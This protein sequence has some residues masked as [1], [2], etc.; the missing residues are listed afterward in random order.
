[1]FYRRLNPEIGQVAV[2]HKGMPHA[3]ELRFLTLALSVQSGVGIGRRGVRVI[4][5]RLPVKV[6]RVVSA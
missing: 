5:E 6:H 4:R 1:M 3:T 2:L